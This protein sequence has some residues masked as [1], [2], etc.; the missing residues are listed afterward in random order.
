MPALALALRS[1]NQFLY[2]DFGVAGSKGLVVGKDGQLFQSSYIREFC[3]RDI[4]PE[5]DKIKS[6][7]DSIRE[8]QGRA[9]AIGKGFIYVITPSKAAQYPEYLPAKPAC[10]ALVNGQT[11]KLAAFRAVLDARAV[12]YVDT[13]SIVGSAKARFPIDL[14]PRGGTHWNMLGASV[15][16]KEVIHSLY[17]A[18]RNLTMGLF[19]FTYAVLGK[20]T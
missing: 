4:A 18:E 11:N 3:G 15:V 19:N 14:F 10:R 16:L 1:K 20:C 7:A 17:V 9:E 13:T 8:I 2:S 6:W 5:P 12:R